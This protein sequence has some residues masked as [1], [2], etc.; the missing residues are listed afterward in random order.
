M[1][2]NI[3][4]ASEKIIGRPTC[5]KAGNFIVEDFIFHDKQNTPLAPYIRYCQLINNHLEIEW[6]PRYSGIDNWKGEDFAAPRI[7]LAYI[8]SVKVDRSEIL[9]EIVVGDNRFSKKISGLNISGA[10]EVS[11]IAKDTQD[12]ESTPVFVIATSA[13]GLLSS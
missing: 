13:S 8:I 4:T 7:N 5:F 12:R 9:R 2:A 3:I 6:V 1:S 10:V 11:I